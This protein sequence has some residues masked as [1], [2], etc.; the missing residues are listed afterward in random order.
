SIPFFMSS[1][2]YG[3]FFDNTYKTEFDFGRT[4]PDYY[5]FEAPGGELVYYFIYGKDYKEI[6][7]GYTQL[8][9]KPIMPP[10]WALGFSQSRGMLTN[11]ILTREIAQGYRDRQIPC[12]IIY[13]D[14]GWVE[15][16]QNFE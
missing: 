12:D 6:I 13:Q 8:T 10:K 7:H 16:L 5:S 4:S 1:Y 15:G 3:I 11:E 14:I 9:G 2:N